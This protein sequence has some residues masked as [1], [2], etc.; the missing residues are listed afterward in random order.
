VVK[1]G[2]LDVRPIALGRGVVDAEEQ[3]VGPGQHRLERR[4]GESGGHEVGS[5][6]D[7]GDGGVGGPEVVADAGGAQPTGDGASA[8]GENRT[9][10]E[11]DEARGR[12]RVEEVGQLGK[13]LAR[14]GG[15]RA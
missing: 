3:A 1:A 6:G 8:G 15:G 13:P 5:F 4:M 12:T 2:P 9:E 11:T 7:S 14:S 10:E